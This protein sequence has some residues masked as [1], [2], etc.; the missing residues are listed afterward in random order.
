MQLTF[1]SYNYLT[2]IW[3][4]PR[5]LDLAKLAQPRTLDSGWGRLPV[6]LTDSV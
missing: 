1:P 3:C 6:L 2:V 4:I 5:F